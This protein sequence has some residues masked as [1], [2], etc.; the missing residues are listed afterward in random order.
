MTSLK[1]E[2]Q[3]QNYLQKK[4]TYG[5]TISA[6]ICPVLKDA[7][8]ELSIKISEDPAIVDNYL[9]QVKKDQIHAKIVKRLEEVEKIKAEKLRLKQLRKEK[10]KEKGEDD[11]DSFEDDDFDNQLDESFLDMEEKEV[12]EHG[13]FQIIPHTP[14]LPATR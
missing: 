4:D 14:W 5:S 2:K 6:A 8:K 9:H 3:L 7:I 12:L 1:E 11:E 13:K 10:E